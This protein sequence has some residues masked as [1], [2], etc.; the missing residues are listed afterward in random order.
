MSCTANVL[1][2]TGSE[3]WSRT[4]SSQNTGPTILQI[5]DVMGE[6]W[7]GNLGGGETIT[8]RSMGY[9]CSL[10]PQSIVYGYSVNICQ[11]GHCT[12]E[13]RSE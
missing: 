9:R 10:P 12:L 3:Y 11:V 1:S 7:G 5:Y 8:V 4:V 6:T 2:N 13:T